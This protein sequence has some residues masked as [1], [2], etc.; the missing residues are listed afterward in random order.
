MIKRNWIWKWIAI[1]KNLKYITFGYGK[2]TNIWGWKDDDL[3]AK[4]I[5]KTCACGSLEGRVCSS[6]C[7]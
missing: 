4:K 7:W 6:S 5:D 2:I 1:T 3:V